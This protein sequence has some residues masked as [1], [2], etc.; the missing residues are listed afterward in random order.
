[1]QRVFEIT[2]NGEPISYSNKLELPDEYRKVKLPTGNLSGSL[3]LK[4]EPNSL[5]MH[6]QET[7]RPRLVKVMP[8]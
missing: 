3:E 2:I 5:Y 6:Q 4:Y 8:W 7:G 1:M